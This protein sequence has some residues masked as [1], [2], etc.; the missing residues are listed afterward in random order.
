MWCGGDAADLFDPC[1]AARV[2]KRRLLIE[3]ALGVATPAR[4]VHG[5]GKGNA[6][7]KTNRV[8]NEGVDARHV[9]SHQRDREETQ[10]KQVLAGSAAAGEQ[11]NHATGGGA[12]CWAVNQALL[13]IAEMRLRMPSYAAYV[14]FRRCF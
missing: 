6:G 2:G 11:C 8:V 14:V 10:R 7:G 13:G 4:R 3:N 9:P 12:R 1:A 5:A